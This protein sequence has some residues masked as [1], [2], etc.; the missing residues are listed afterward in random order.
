VTSR[1]K[2]RRLRHRRKRRRTYDGSLRSLSAIGG[3]RHHNPSPT[4]ELIQRRVVWVPTERFSSNDPFLTDLRIVH[5]RGV[6]PVCL[7]SPPTSDAVAVCG[8]RDEPIRKNGLWEFLLVASCRSSG[9]GGEFRK[10]SMA[11][12]RSARLRHKVWENSSKSRCSCSF[13]RLGKLIESMEA[14]AK[15]LLS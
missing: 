13:A 3:N 11:S 15:S 8:F 5:E 9:R 1:E 12:V 14:I 4:N 10:W 6:F 7:A 2:W